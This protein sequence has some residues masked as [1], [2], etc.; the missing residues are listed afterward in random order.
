MTIM[1]NRNI[2]SNFERR[3]SIMAKAASTDPLQLFDDLVPKAFQRATLRCLLDTYTGVYTACEGARNLPREE[4]HD[5]RPHLRRSKFD[6]EWRAVAARFPSL[7]ATVE[8]NVGKNCYHTLI[9]AGRVRL[10]ASAVDS[11]S[12]VVR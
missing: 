12:T 6:A 1:L 10:T 9:S 8:K 7:T 5:V 2:E 3:A 4:S 11:D